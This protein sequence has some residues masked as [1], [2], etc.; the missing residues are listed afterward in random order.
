MENIVLAAFVIISA[1]ILISGIKILY[2]VGK[3]ILRVVF[4][5]IRGMVKIIA[6]PFRKARESF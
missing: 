1:S 4:N 3:G 5:L 2:A 6:T